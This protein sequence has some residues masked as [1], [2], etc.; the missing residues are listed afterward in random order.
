MK[1]KFFLTGLVCWYACIPTIS[2]TEY[3]PEW[4]IK[5][6][7]N[8]NDNHTFFEEQRKTHA[9][10]FD[11]KT[12]ADL[13]ELAAQ[14]TVGISII[15]I[16]DYILKKH[17]SH[18]SKV[19]SKNSIG[20]IFYPGQ[21]SEN[22]KSVAGAHEAKEAL[23]DIVKFL[24]NP[25][26]CKKLGAKIPK[27]I[28]LTG[29]PGTGKTLLA[30]ALAGEAHCNF[31]SVSG[32]AFIEMYVGVGAARI[33]ALFEQATAHAPCI[34]FIDEID[35]VGSKRMADLGMGGTAEH[36][37]TVNQLLTCMDGFATQNDDSPV[38]IIG[39]TN[40]ESLLDPALLRPGRFD[41]IIEISLPCAKDRE[42]ILKIHLGKIILAPKID[43]KTIA[44]RTPG[45]SGAQLQQVVNQAA[46]I[47]TKKNLNAVGTTE[48]HEA[49]DLI[50]LGAP[51]KHIKLSTQDKR[52]TAYHEAGHALMHL[53][54]PQTPNNL[55]GV[56]IIPRNRALGLT[57]SLPEDNKFNWNKNEMLA[58]ICVSLAGRAAEE[59][60]FNEIS[61][62]AH[63]D[64][65]YASNLAQDMVCHYGMTDNLGKRI[66]I[67]KNISEEMQ[68]KIDNEISKILAEQYDRVIKLLKTNKDMLIKLAEALLKKETMYSSEIYALLG[69]KQPKSTSI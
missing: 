39:A 35:A 65:E 55:Y 6:T 34:V 31:I 16:A 27:G 58:L 30:R 3:H 13:I 50:T 1:L 36:N 24:K 8:S 60:I 29:K 44:Q 11:A 66:Y 14:L 12:K 56:T 43:V 23:Q 64:F 67:Q 62:G 15:L 17:D 53:L 38:I 61:T 63:A 68:A 46:M 7:Q 28:L 33:R 4:P 49:I 57:Y 19:S 26:C 2:K 41:K 21:I 47:A 51:A 69:I 18:N 59:L 40:H 10:F 45:F 5:A 54:I 32:S 37:H 9:A 20:D 22:F 25:E 48:L 42:D 52:I